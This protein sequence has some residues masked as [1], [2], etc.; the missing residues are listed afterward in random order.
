MHN[1]LY[2]EIKEL[3][4]DV[5]NL[6]EADISAKDIQ[7]DDPLIGPDSPLGIDSLDAIEIVAAVEKR[8]G[9]RINNVDT[10]QALLKSVRI[11][12]DFISAKQNENIRIRSASA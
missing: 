11:L 4:V 12:A 10:A 5:C 1:E 6:K 3:I 7:L 8:Y 2:S 9:V